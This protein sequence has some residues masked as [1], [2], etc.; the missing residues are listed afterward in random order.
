[1]PGFF[2]LVGYN[3][4]PHGKQTDD[5]CKNIQKTTLLME[6]MILKFAFFQYIKVA[7]GCQS[8]KMFTL[9]FM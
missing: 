7:D 5:L 8:V 4:D 2:E 9:I 1:M 6:E 3:I